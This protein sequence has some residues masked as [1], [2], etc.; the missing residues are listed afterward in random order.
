VISL[1]LTIDVNDTRTGTGNV[2]CASARKTRHALV[3][4][5]AIASGVCQANHGRSTKKGMNL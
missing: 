5:S 4:A 1:I 3:C 2:L